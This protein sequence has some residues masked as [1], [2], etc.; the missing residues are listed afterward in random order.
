MFG[1]IF[2]LLPTLLVVFCL[3]II[4]CPLFKSDGTLNEKCRK[5]IKND[6]NFDKED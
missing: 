2:I 3:G 6:S 5:N 1:N 4:S